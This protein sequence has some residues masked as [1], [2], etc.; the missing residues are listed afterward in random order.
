VRILL[1]GD[2]VGR[3]GRKAVAAFLAG[4]G[5][6]CDIVVANGENAAGG[7]GLTCSTADELFSA[8]VHVIT[9]GNHIWKQK[10]IFPRL[11]EENS[12][13]LRPA[14]APPGNPGTGV[15][16]FDAAGIRVRVLNLQGRT[17]MD[18]FWD[19]PFRTADRILSGSRPHLTIVDFHCEATSEKQVMG[20]FLDGRVTA[21]AG[22][23]T[24]VLTADAG[25]L[26]GGTAYI[27]DLG[28]CGSH[29]G[30]IGM[31]YDQARLRFLTGRPEKLTAA[32]GDERING[33]EI[34]LDE[35]LSVES[36]RTI[37]ERVRL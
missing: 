30:I 5:S 34:T 15:C 17:F 21:V 4:S 19:C 16:E 33:L 12:R 3:P 36:C 26:P 11:E 10:E 8:G 22:T 28:M 25:V 9:S 32:K 1:L 20:R 6:G 7:F 23:H 29:A 27:T 14:N 13:I 18:G 24:H 37:D 2:I 35:E 31:A